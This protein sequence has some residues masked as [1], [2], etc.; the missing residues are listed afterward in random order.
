MLNLLPRVS[1]IFVSRHLKISYSAAVELASLA[2]WNGLSLRREISTQPKRAGLRSIALRDG[3]LSIRLERLHDHLD[4]WIGLDG[5]DAGV[6]R[7]LTDM[8]EVLRKV[9]TTAEDYQRPRRSWW[10]VVPADQ[11]SFIKFL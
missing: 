7:D 9:R 2:F 8:R 11:Y 10:A 3:G 6:I 1:G 4:L 5:K